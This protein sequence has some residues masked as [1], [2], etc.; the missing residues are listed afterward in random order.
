M[1]KSSDLRPHSLCLRQAQAGPQA[2][3]AL[4]GLLWPVKGSGPGVV[5]TD[6]GEDSGGRSR[7]GEGG[8]NAVPGQRFEGET[9]D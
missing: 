3:G 7:R 2:R 5:D 8:G 4:T 6:S 1:A 9:Q